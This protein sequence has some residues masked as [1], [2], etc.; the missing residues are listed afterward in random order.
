[1]R[2]PVTSSTPSA[3]SRQILSS[4]A[5]CHSPFVSSGR[6][7][8]GCGS[9]PIIVIGPSESWSRMP[10]AAMS[11]VMP[12]P[13]IRY[14]VV[15]ILA[16]VSGDTHLGDTHLGD[17]VEFEER[18]EAL[19]LL[20]TGRTA[21]EVGAKAGDESVGRSSREL[22]LDV[23]VELREALVAA[24]LRLVAAEQ[25]LECGVEVASGHSFA[26][27]YPAAATCSR[28]RRRAS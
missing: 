9:A 28:S 15:C 17:R 18:A 4:G 5:P 22:Q 27:G 2:R 10:F 25:A 1:M 21:D 8:G 12:A 16:L 11:P 20:G 26:S 3:G 13:T 14:L 24:D 19:V 23:A 7:Y 6:L